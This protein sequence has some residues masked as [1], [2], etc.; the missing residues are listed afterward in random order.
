MLVGSVNPSILFAAVSR[1]LGSDL[2]SR[3]Q[4]PWINPHNSGMLAALRVALIFL[5]FFSLPS[6]FPTKPRMRIPAKHVYYYRCPDH[7]RNYVLTFSFCF[8]R[9]KDV[10]Q[11]SYCYPYSYTRLQNYLD[12]L[13]KRS[14]E[15][16]QRELL[17]LSVVG[18]PPPPTPLYLD[19]PWLSLLFPQL[20]YKVRIPILTARSCAKFGGPPDFFPSYFPSKVGFPADLS[21]I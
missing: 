11:F 9:E 6:Y 4:R 5:C 1:V 14:L 12:N 2:L 20:G 8:D 3:A 10:Y 16:C 15:Y 21:R 17:C 19:P 13:E 18:L 7:R